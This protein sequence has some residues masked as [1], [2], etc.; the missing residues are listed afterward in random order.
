VDARPALLLFYWSLDHLAAAGI[1]FEEMSDLIVGLG[2]G[3]YAEAGG[4]GA[5]VSD[6][7]LGCDKFEQIERDVFCAA[8]C[9]DGFHE[10]IPLVSL[11][12]MLMAAMVCAQMRSTFGE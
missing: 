9:V 5:F 4:T 8:R 2:A 12:L 1:E 7:S 10:V 6:V 11:S 3:G